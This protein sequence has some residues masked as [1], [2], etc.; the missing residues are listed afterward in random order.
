MS[1]D[2]LLRPEGAH[3]APD[4]HDAAFA[5][6][7][8]R[9]RQVLT[10]IVLIV[11]VV[12]LGIVVGQILSTGSVPWFAI[13]LAVVFVMVIGHG[14]TIGY[15]RLF[16]HRSFEACR[17]L[18]VTLALLGS[19]SFQGSLIG[20]VADHR[21]H[22]RYTDRVGDPHSPQWIGSE[23]ARGLRGLWHAHIGWT[24][25]GEL[26][27]REQYA[28]DLLGDADLVFVDKLFVPC[29]ILTLAIPFALGVLW[30]G[31]VGGGVIALL[32]AGLIRVGITHNFTWSI[33]SICHRF[34]T[35]TFATRDTSTN[36]AALA[37]LTMGESFHNNH[38][39]FPRSARHGLDPGQFDTSAACIRLFERLGWVTN[40]QWPDPAL[41][42]ARRTRG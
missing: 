37:L 5:A 34:G 9:Y 6:H 32:I 7:P 40:V 15:H 18:K 23:P 20:W 38:H 22:H 2:L 12:V 17:P 41:L 35:R 19:M 24:F 26:T 10:A 11:P 29:C 27:P 4:S 1:S 36:V 28:S 8:E 31:T 3:A 33:N 39:A 13:V 16:T 25:R 42:S 30:T 14:V 21:R